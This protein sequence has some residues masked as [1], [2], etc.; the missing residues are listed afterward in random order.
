MIRSHRSARLALACRARRRMAQD[1]SPRTPRARRSRPPPRSSGDI[2]RIGDLVDNAGAVADVAIFR[3][4]DLGTTGTVPA[5]ACSMRCGAHS[6]VG[7]DTHGL[8]E[9]EVTRAE[10]RDHPPADRSADRRARSPATTASA[11]PRTSA[12]PS[13]A[14]RAPSMSSRPA[15]AILRD[16]APDLRPAHRPLRR[17]LRSAG[18]R[19]RAARCRCASPAPSPR[20]SRS[21]V[22]DAPDRRAARSS[23]SPTSSSSAGRRPSRPAT[24]SPT[25]TQAI[26]F[27]ARQPLRPGQPLRTADLMKPEM[28]QRND[29]VTL[30]YE[31]PGILLTMRGKA[32][33]AGAEGD[34]INVAQRAIEAHRAG[35]R[36]SGPG[37]VSITADARRP[38]ACERRGS[39][40]HVQ[41]TSRPEPSESHV[42]SCLHASSLR[43]QR[44]RSLGL[45]RSAAAR[46]FD[47]LQA[48]GEQ[49]PLAAIDNPTRSPATSRCRCR[50]RRRSRRPTIRTRCG[51]TARAPSSRTSARTRSATSS[52]SR[53]TSPTRPTSPTR[54]SAAAPT[55]KIPASPI[56]SAPRPSS[57]PAT[58][59]L[60]GRI[61]TADS[62]A[63]SDGKGSVN[64]Q[65]ALADQRRRRWSRRSCRTA[66]W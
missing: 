56:S 47:R 11:R 38:G 58:A 50:C 44:L 43:R 27:A 62:T 2:V 65:E 24:S 30:V 23:R 15:P 40:P 4:P 18:Q 22:I 33:E 3:S 46:R 57:N 7:V 13:T 60:P 66:T 59:I 52:R 6:I 32:L 12:S 21:P 37:R 20:P 42:R 1:A 63:S 49:P 53:S 41:R 61:L 9:I 5:S 51:A 10:P 35:H 14:S 39:D 16:R 8:T 26:G 17:Q 19:R 31:V 36:Q 45:A 28:V 34:I 25:P 29:N 55:R 64:R 54:R 48:I